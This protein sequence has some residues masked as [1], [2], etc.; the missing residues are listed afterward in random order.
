MTYLNFSSKCTILQELALADGVGLDANERNDAKDAKDAISKI[1]KL[2]DT[3]NII[4]HSM[5]SPTEVGI[6]FSSH[7]QKKLVMD[8]S[9]TIEENELRRKREVI[10]ESWG[11]VA[12][13]AAKIRSK[14]REK[15]IAEVVLRARLAITAAEVGSKPH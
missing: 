3:R 15:R 13:M 5:F 6:K 11:N 7:G 14:A 2:A 12:S 1:R 10:A 4:A 8:R 9:T